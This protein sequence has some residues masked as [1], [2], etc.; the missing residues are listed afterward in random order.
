MNTMLRERFL[1]GIADKMAMKDYFEAWSE[2]LQDEA[3]DMDNKGK[4]NDFND[5]TPDAKEKRNKL[6]KGTKCAIS[7]PFLYTKTNADRTKVERTQALYRTQAYK[8]TY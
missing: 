7:P 1:K 8:Q 5:Q 6:H 2:Y 3:K 4:G